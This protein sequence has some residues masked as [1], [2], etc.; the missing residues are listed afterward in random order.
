ME[1]IQEHRRLPETPYLSERQW[2]TV[3][4]DYRSNGDPVGV[5]PMRARG[6]TAGAKTDWGV[7]QGQVLAQLL[8]PKLEHQNGEIDAVSDSLQSSEVTRPDRP[9]K[10]E[11]NGQA[12]VEQRVR[13]RLVWA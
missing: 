1:A 4:E 10:H 8:M 3:R 11:E 9:K 12:N 7:E 13:R 5:F 2:G 6:P